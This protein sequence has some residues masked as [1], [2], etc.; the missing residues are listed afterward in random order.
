MADAKTALAK[1]LSSSDLDKL[2]TAYPDLDRAFKVLNAKL[3]GYNNLWDYYDGN[4][5]LMY[6]AKRMRDLFADLELSTFVENWC[7]VVIDA[8][9]DR[10][11]LAS[12]SVKDATSN[13]LIEE[14][15]HTK[16][17]GLE[18]SDV[19]EAALVVGESYLIVWPD[20]DEKVEV[21]YNDPRLVHLFY[22]PA[23]PRKKWYGAKWWVAEDQHMRITLYYDDRLEYYRSSQLAKNVASV[24]AFL[25]YSPDETEGGAVATHEYGEVPIFHFR[26]ERRKVKGDLVNA[27]PLQNGINK[28]LTD[29]MVA[30]EY[31]AYKQR[32]V[33]SQADTS[34]LK[35]APGM[36]WEIP[37]GDGVG[38]GTQ[39]GEFDA[40]DLKNYIQGIDQLSSSMAI[41]TR[42][43]KHYLF[44][45]GGDPSGEA[46]IAMESPLNKRCKDHI[47]KFI[48]VWKEVVIF[49]L[50]VLNVEAKKEDVV[51]TFDKPET[52]LPVTEATIRTAGK[53]AGLPLKT[54]L[55]D[56]G[57]DEA[58]MVQMEKDKKEEQK[59]NATSL[60]VALATSLRNANQ[61][62]EEETE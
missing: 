41:I 40:T 9:N 49:I 36:M 31:G 8:A 2:D 38:E 32:W 17:I 15:W 23:N 62:E 58:W 3:T 5:P 4:Q 14:A 26:L 46:L 19:H 11:N 39:V 47:D 22:D 48:P 1:S 21:F 7:A 55:R 45:Q 59:E 6:T 12:V 42:T 57:K 53:A 24:K 13:G 34:G 29:M 50:K 28:L 35:N 10:I 61:P 27:V 54:M 37:G 16:E 56:E 43:P 51:I 30:A 18:A 44:Q 20:E 33:V 60:A 52:I 25:P